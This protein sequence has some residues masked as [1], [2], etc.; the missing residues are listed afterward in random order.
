MEKL[1]ERKIARTQ[2]I[3]E[4][5]KKNINQQGSYNLSI[6]VMR[7]LKY[8]NVIK[9]LSGNTSNQLYIIDPNYKLVLKEN[10]LELIGSNYKEI[11]NSLV[12]NKTTAADGTEKFLISKKSNSDNKNWW[13]VDL[14]NKNIEGA[15]FEISTNYSEKKVFIENTLPR[16]FRE[17]EIVLDDYNAELGDSETTE[18]SC[19]EIK[20][21][22]KIV[23]GVPGT[24]KSSYLTN[25]IQKEYPDYKSKGSD[26]VF[27]VTMHPEYS[28][29]DF[30]G[31]IMPVVKK[32]ETESI[33]TYSF[34]E[35]IFT[36]ALKKAIAK[37][38]KNIYLVI[39]EMSRGNIA[40]IF[41]DI[42]QLL[43]RNSEGVSE[44]GIKNSLISKEIYEN[45]DLEIK[46]PSNLSILGTL[47][48]SDQNVFVM[49]NAFK[50]RFDFE[51]MTISPIDK[52]NDFHF[53]LD[54][55]E[56][57]WLDFYI[58]LNDYIVRELRLSEDKQIGQ[59]FFK[60]DE[61]S[62][63]EKNYELFTN[64]ILNYIWFDIHSNALVGNSIIDENI[65]CFED[66]YNNFKNNK[67]I[68]KFEFINYFDKEHENN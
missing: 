46:L 29:F 2:S 25:L 18:N 6:D 45:E 48:T 27:R 56:I 66:A 13:F 55:I 10:L 44:Y 34:V 30:V 40:S 5:N 19:V 32:E 43:D 36:K 11:N 3:Y 64:K 67:N 59:F 63:K 62:S 33:I 58:K 65:T 35:G 57:S 60:Y 38:K 20:P 50:R 28:Y 53:V 17:K 51:Y 9:L 14:Y 26:Y 49:D 52:L 22:Q 4:L 42:F 31:N 15:I 24:G 1:I 61:N 54:D 16:E 12:F 37:P 23:F 21:T 8:E 39:E 68:F 7:K 41:G 47:N